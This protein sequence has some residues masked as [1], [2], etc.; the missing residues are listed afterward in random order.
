LDVNPFDFLSNSNFSLFDEINAISIPE[1]KA[2]NTSVI[3]ISN[4]VDIA[5]VKVENIFS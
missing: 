4:G 5:R 3:I 1:K 2:D